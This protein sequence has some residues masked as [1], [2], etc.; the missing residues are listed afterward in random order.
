MARKNVDFNHVQCLRYKIH[1][2][3]FD[4]VD[5]C[6]FVIDDDFVNDHDLDNDQD[7]VQNLDIV[8]DHDDVNDHDLDNDR[9][10]ILGTTFDQFLLCILKRNDCIS[11]QVVSVNSQRRYH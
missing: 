6:D 8:N 4:F 2:Q 9:D 7:F 10:F 3:K 1:R 5:D 11:N